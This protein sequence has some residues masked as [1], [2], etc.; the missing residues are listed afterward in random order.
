MEE[1]VLVG[2]IR[3]VAKGRPTSRPA[4]KGL[5]IEDVIAAIKNAPSELCLA[6]GGCGWTIPRRRRGNGTLLGPNWN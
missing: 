6:W 5:L 3:M 2:V 4:I 1:P